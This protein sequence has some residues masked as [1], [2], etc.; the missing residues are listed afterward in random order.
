MNESA[1]NQKT[2]NAQPTGFD[3]SRRYVRVLEIR[4]DGFVLFE[5]AVGEPD[6]CAEMMLTQSGFIEFCAAQQV[7]FLP[8]ETV[9]HS[10]QAH[11]EMDWQLR[12]VQKFLQT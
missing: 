4:T 5:F 8:N 3:V 12:D 10:V 1:I 2:A 11:H 6:I 7:Q 9:E